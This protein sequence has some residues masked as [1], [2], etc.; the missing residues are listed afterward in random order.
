MQQLPPVT[1]VDEMAFDGCGDRHCGRDQM[2]AASGPL[3]AFEVAIA[4]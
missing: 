4:R 2:S 1:D 3:T